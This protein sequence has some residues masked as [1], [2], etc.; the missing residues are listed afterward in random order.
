VD[1][2]EGSITVKSSPGEGTTFTVKLPIDHETMNDPSQ[3]HGPAR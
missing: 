2:H 3:T 1:E